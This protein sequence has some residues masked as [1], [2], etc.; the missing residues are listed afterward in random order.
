MDA[1]LIGTYIGPHKPSNVD[2]YLHDF[3]EEYKALQR[4]GFRVCEGHLKVS[5]RAFICDAPARSFICGIKGHTSFNGCTKC[6]QIGRRIGNVNTF[7]TKISA[8]R[9]DS[10]F[11]QRSDLNFHNVFNQNFKLEM[12]HLGIKMISQFPVEPMHMVD[13]GVTK[14]ILLFISNNKTNFK[15]T[16]NQ[17]LEMS[18]ALLSI[19]P[20]IPKEFA[21]KPRDLD[22]LCRWKAT[23]FRQFILYTSI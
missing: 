1:F 11:D 9:T 22:E 16:N 15:L 17:K 6:H 18:G 5:I 3:L 2:N 7:S 12:E 8:L 14:K 13:L 10:E 23:E 4:N 21:R 20:Y 19:S